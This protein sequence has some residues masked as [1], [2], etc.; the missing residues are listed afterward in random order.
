MNQENIRFLRENYISTHVQ[1]SVPAF[2][3]LY[4]L[5]GYP[6]KIYY[7]NNVFKPMQKYE[8]FCYGQN[9]SH[10]IWKSFVPKKSENR[11]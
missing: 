8:Y 6:I 7:H 4:V 10:S 1:P 3:T 9:H 5:L 2:E 11:K